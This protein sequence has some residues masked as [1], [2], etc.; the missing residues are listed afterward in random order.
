MDA[1]API[2]GS[3]LHR[4]DV[5][6][7]GR[8]AMHRLYEIQNGAHRDSWGEPPTNF[9]EVGYLLP[10]YVEAFDSLVKWVENGQAPPQGQC[11]PRGGHLVYNPPAA[12]C[13]SLL[14]P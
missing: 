14:A 3:R 2:L 13:P 11:V 5:I 9:A 10:S 7:Q 8:A 4:A 1:T 6:A 12:H